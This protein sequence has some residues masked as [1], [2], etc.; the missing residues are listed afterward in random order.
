MTHLAVISRGLALPTTIHA[1]GAK[2]GAIRTQ[3]L[4]LFLD[5]RHGSSVNTPNLNPLLFCGAPASFVPLWTC[6]GTSGKPKMNG[7]TLMIAPASTKQK[8]MSINRRNRH[9]WNFCPCL[10]VCYSF[11]QCSRLSSIPMH[12][13]YSVAYSENF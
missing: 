1:K 13:I 5:F 8:W 6:S 10:I 4:N 11:D 2:L 12:Y 9:F 3:S 7:C